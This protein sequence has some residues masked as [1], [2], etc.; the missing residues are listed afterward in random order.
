[1]QASK[2][3][4]GEEDL[5]PLPRALAQQTKKTGLIMVTEGQA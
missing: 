5:G 3:K 4:V 2:G 1:M